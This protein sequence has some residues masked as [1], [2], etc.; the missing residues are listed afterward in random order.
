MISVAC[1][2]IM[3]GYCPLSQAFKL[4]CPGKEYKV[5]IALRRLFQ[6]PVA[7]ICVGSRLSI[8]RESCMVSFSIC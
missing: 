1:R 5:D 4:A 7:A 6:M 3:E 2:V 8:E